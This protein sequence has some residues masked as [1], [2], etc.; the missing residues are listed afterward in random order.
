MALM[1]PGDSGK[2]N[3]TPDDVNSAAMT[4]AKQ[5]DALGNGLVAARGYGWE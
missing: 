2:I 3:V 5:Q 1:S 4:F